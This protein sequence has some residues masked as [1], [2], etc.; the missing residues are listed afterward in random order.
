MN[1]MSSVVKGRQIVKKTLT[2]VAAC[3]VGVF[4]GF[5]IRMEISGQKK[6]FQQNMKC[7]YGECRKN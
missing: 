6:I 4:L 1:G 3:G 7:P 5:I 2:L